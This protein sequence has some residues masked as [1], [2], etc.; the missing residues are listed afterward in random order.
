MVVARLLIWLIR[1]GLLALRRLRKDG[2]GRARQRSQQHG[3][4]GDSI[5]CI[6]R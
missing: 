1:W 2:A 5:Q 3:P 4:E 6:H